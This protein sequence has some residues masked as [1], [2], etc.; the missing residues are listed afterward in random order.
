MIDFWYTWNLWKMCDTLM[1][2]WKFMLLKYAGKKIK[3][4]IFDNCWIINIQYNKCCSVI[5][6]NL[7]ILLDDLTI[8]SY[9]KILWYNST[10]YNFW[11]GLDRM[12]LKYVL[13]V[14]SIHISQC[15]LIKNMT[16]TCEA[17]PST[18]SIVILG[19]GMGL[20]CDNTNFPILCAFSDLPNS[21][22]N[23]T[24]LIPWQ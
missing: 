5:I 3:Y 18:L 15:Y 22:I 7:H 9:Y 19:E 10:C 13:N 11:Q 21:N 12:I 23:H 17:K 2:T 6:V 8:Q 4:Q 20:T 24:Y 1:V 14:A 16:K